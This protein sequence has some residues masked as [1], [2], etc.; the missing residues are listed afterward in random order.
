MLATPLAAVFNSAISFFF[1]FITSYTG[2]KSLS[3]ST[4]RFFFG[5][6]FTCPSEAFT[7]NCLPRY[8]PIVFAFAGDS[9]MTRLFSIVTMCFLVYESETTEILP[10]SAKTGTEHSVPSPPTRCRNGQNGRLH[11]AQTLI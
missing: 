3:T 11:S 2:L 7:T 8:L 9:T 6:S 10:Q 4:E 5:R 1:P